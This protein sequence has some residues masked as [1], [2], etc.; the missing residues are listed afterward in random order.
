MTV[1]LYHVTLTNVYSMST[2]REECEFVIDPAEQERRAT[3][4]FRSFR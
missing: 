3:L 1:Q 4:A 2:D